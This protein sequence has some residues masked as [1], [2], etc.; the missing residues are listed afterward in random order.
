MNKQNREGAGKMP[1]APKFKLANDLNAAVSKT[2]IQP[3]ADVPATN[4]RD[5]DGKTCK[6]PNNFS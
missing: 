5:H 1:P 3:S 2:A 6:A 4:L